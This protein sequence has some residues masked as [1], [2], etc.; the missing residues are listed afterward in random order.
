MAFGIRGLSQKDIDKIK[1][2]TKEVVESNPNDSTIIENIDVIL[3]E[4][5]NIIGER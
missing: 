5:R 2:V 3:K 1:G 4:K